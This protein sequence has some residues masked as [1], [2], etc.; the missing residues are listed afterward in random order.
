[1]PYMDILEVS[2]CEGFRVREAAASALGPY[3]CYELCPQ[4]AIRVD[5]VLRFLR[6]RR[7]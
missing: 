2:P 1:M 3:C 6:S 7:F 4:Q 5:R